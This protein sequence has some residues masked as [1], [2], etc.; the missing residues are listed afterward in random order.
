MRNRRIKELKFGKKILETIKKQT[1]KEIDINENKEGDSA[2]IL[3]IKMKNLELFN[4][5]IINFL[6]LII[7]KDSKPYK[8]N[9]FQIMK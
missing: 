9:L 5:I 3:L 8:V 7:Q 4:M 2:I 6:L 1:N